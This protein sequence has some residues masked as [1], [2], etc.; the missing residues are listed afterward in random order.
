MALY[1]SFGQTYFIGIFGPQIQDEFGLSHTVWGS[2]YLAGTLTS[3]LLM[4][5]TGALI[6]RYSLSV[7]ALAVGLALLAACAF[8][9]VASGPLML[10]VAI[11]L[12][13]QSGQGLA[14]HVSIT[15]MARYFDKER[16]RAIAVASMGYSVGEAVLPF[17]AVILIAMIG[18]RWTYG[19]AAILIGVTLI[20]ATI[21]LLSNHDRFH[22]RYLRQ[23]SSKDDSTVSNS[24]SWT[25]AQVLRDRRF[26][27]ISPG[28]LSSPMIVTAFFFH[29][30][31]VADAKGW[32]GEWITGTYIFYALA[33][34]VTVL[35][36]GPLV[37]RFRARR[38]IQIMLI[39][40]IGACLML[41]VADHALWA[42]PYMIMM[43]LHTGL[44]HTSA[45]ALWAE[46]YGPKHLGAIKSLYLALMV[47][48]SAVG[49]VVMGMLMDAGLSIYQVCSLFGGFIALGAVLIVLA[50]RMKPAPPHIVSA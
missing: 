34:I 3:A 41:A 43:G 47:F 14:S 40:L 17:L 5:F 33:G 8:I 44:I 36:A 27:V 48:A 28:I 4:P 26:Y 21:W 19:S 16:G 31:N 22:R 1:S 39:P 2:I 37:D 30:M 12:L 50:L 10:V 42:I 25:R 6:D 11:F 29:H 24:V 49:P 23:L 7:Y 9:S 46:L 18:W 32:S 35:L 15:S 45:S 38:V 20:P 13:R